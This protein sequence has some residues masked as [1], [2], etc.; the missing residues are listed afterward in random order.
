[1]AY[2]VLWDEVPAGTKAYD[3]ANKIIFGVGPLT[4]TGAPCGGRTSITAISPW[5][6]RW[7]W[8]PPATWAATAEPS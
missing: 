7:T 1:M 8:W 6:I 2:K 4:G 5:R 3:E